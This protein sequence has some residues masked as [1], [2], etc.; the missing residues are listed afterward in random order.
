MQRRIRG[1]IEWRTLWLTLLTC[2]CTA[3]LLCLRNTHGHQYLPS[4]LTTLP[5]RIKAMPEVIIESD[6]VTLAL[7]CKMH[8]KV[9]ISFLYGACSHS[10]FVTCRIYVCPVWANG[11]AGGLTEGNRRDSLQGS[12]ETSN[13]DAF[14][15]T[16]RDPPTCGEPT[17]LPCQ[18]LRCMQGNSVP[19]WATTGE[20]RAEGASFWHAFLTPFWGPKKFFFSKQRMLKPMSGLSQIQNK[21]SK[22][23]D[24]I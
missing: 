5:G 22:S 9:N 11:S 18:R 24:Q 10:W 12:S 13:C 17:S 14:S 4:S 16:Y 19:Q 20:D 7:F 3:V 15:A 8:R 6:P 23:L 1:C 2:Q 21:P